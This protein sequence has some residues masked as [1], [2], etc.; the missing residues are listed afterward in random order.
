VADVDL[1]QAGLPLTVEDRAI[2]AKESATVVGHIGKIVLVSST[3][4]TAA[5]RKSVSTRLTAT[6][7]LTRKLGGSPSAP[8]WVPDDEFAIDEHIVEWRY[9][10]PLAE[11]E[12]AETVAELF[13][14]RLDRRRPLWRMDVIHPLWNG[15]SAILWRVSHAL[16]D[17]ATW[18]KFAAALLWDVGGDHAS[19]PEATVARAAAAA[20][21]SHHRHR[22]DLAGLVRR[23][24]GRVH[25][26]SPFDGRIGS[27]RAVSFASTSLPELRAAAKGVDRAAT[28]NDAVLASVAGGLRTWLGLHD[29][30]VGPLRCKV[31]V[32]LHH[33]GDDLA[34]RDSFFY[35]NLPLGDPDP[36]ERLRTIRRETSVRKRSHDAEEMD[37][38]LETL[39]RIPH[40]RT[41][42]EQLLFDP[43]R[44]AI[45]I[46]T[47]R[48]PAYAVSV[49]GAPVSALFAIADVAERHALRVAAIS[50]DDQI[51]FGFCADPHLIEDLSTLA[52][53]VATQA[54]ELSRA[55]AGKSAAARPPNGHGA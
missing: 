24:F 7:S 44:F 11:E 17:G 21:A 46:S 2:L 25:G 48:G 8:C 19:P 12:L 39:G 9:S 40:L 43:R 38:L 52:R 28:V 22:R 30:A 1:E 14:E 45:N 37:R 33:A 42:C 20:E 31:P 32:S 35:V 18:V 50:L 29:R 23:E 34:N 4:D 49:L 36:R 13:A 55:S 5:L 51:H 15:G 41:M 6:P 53:A 47:V 27:R 26:R 3:L 10:T 54:T 16:A